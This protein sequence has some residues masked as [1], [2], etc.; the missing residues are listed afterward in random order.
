MPRGELRLGGHKGTLGERC[1]EEGMPR[2]KMCSRR[3]KPRESIGRF[4]FED[5]PERMYFVIAVGAES[6]AKKH[7][8]K[9]G[10]E[11]YYVALIPDRLVGT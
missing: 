4:E 10:R 7:E 3:I 6:K 5:Y 2:F 11:E 1:N 8:W 9:K